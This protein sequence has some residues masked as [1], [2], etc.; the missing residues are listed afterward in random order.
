MKLK[1]LC[2]AAIIA[3]ACQSPVWAKKLS[4]NEINSL[5]SGKKVLLQ[6]SWGAFPLRYASSRRVTGDGTALGL[7]RFFAPKETGKWWVKSD[8]LCQKFPTWYR[9]NTFCF[10][11]EKAG[12][13]KLRW[14][15]DDGYSGTALIQ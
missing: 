9:G 13:K 11:L 1:V 3:V 4:G 10:S 2:G 7:A 5:I 15:R 12:A 14:R 8:R 6:T